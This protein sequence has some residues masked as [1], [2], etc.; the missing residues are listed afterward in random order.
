MGLLVLESVND[1]PVVRSSVKGIA[2][3]STVTTRA[4]TPQEARLGRTISN[5]NG[6]SGGPGTLSHSNTGTS[7]Q[8]NGITTSGAKS[9]TNVT[10]LDSPSEKVMYPFRVKHL[11][12]IDGYVLYAPT[13]QNR[14]EWVDKI[15]EA[16]TR[17]AASLFAQNAEPFR[18]RVMADTAFSYDS[19]SGYPKGTT[20]AGTPLDRA[21]KEVERTHDGTS[22]RLAPVCRAQV[23]CAT[24][25]MQP[26]GQQKVAVG[27]D[28]GVYIT[29]YNNPRGWVRAIAAQRITQ[30]A[31]LDDFSL[32]LVLADK[33]LIAYHLDV[34]CP[35][36]GAP[37]LASETSTRR[38]P[39]KLSGSRD[40]G[41]FATGR[42]K[43]RT[44]VFYKKREG[45]SSTFK[46]LEPVYQ[47]SSTSSRNR[48]GMRK[49]TTEFFRDFDDFYIPSETYAIN[50]FHSSL[51]IA[52]TRGIEVLTLDKKVPFSIPDVK[53]PEVASIAARIR[54]QKPLGMFRL[55]D[56]EFLLVFDEV[57]IYVD[58]HGD[59]SRA[60]VMDFVG[61]A[62]QAALYN[63]TYL[64]LVDIG[65]AYVEVRNAING[66]LRQVVSGRDVRLLDDGV[67]GSTI[68]ICMQH[69]ELERSQV[70]M[71]MIVNEGLKE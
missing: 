58:K 33:V 65:S 5:Q 13:S 11:G 29:D 12:K 10:V 37:T 3:V 27:T 14:Q 68:K 34:V 42:M 22:H 67:N 25:F 52:T 26:Y 71:E 61:K 4:Q 24:A 57:G 16:K 35:V 36:H 18:L 44:L 45:I 53:A 2:S 59:V 56:N 48:F 32:F 1:D 40:V 31:V 49:G 43:D 60:V 9:A 69:P 23:N 20:I 19:N 41:F 54:D 46:V 47:K 62:R 51:A 6:G 15:I 38:A 7:V 8:S 64:V 39:Q 30:I 17:H 21:I 66:R 55:S 28:Y 70:V 63:N 50:L